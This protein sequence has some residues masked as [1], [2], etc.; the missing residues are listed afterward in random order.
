M[1]KMNKKG[2]T[3]IELLAVIVIL[4]LLMAIAIPSVTKYIEQSRRNTLV[5]SI[6]SYISAVM[7]GVNDNEFG[8]MYD[9]TKI[10]YVPVAT[11]A[12][13]VSVEKGGSNPFSEWDQ[14]YVGV[15]YDSTNMSYDYYFI[16]KDK[17]GNGMALT[18]SDAI[19]K[20]VVNQKQELETLNDNV[21][22]G[23]GD[24]AVTY[25]AVN[26]T[27]CQVPTTGA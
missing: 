10:Y 9:S 2:F 6:D 11:S 4:G 1:K 24:D 7:T 21:T 14:A 19:T 16:Y 27:S 20:T 23:T 25:T 17:A 8:S 12:S 26:L 13:C 5:K 18:K 15:I 3:L 22:F